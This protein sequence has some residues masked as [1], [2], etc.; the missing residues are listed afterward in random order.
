MPNKIIAATDKV[1]GVIIPEK[2]LKSAGGIII[3]ETAKNLPQTYVK[4]TSVGPKVEVI[5]EGDVI[6]CHVRGGQDMFID[7]V[8]YKVVTE[9]EVYGVIRNE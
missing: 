8:S 2:E 5:K 4:V 1:I 3:P 7:N 6:V 9:S